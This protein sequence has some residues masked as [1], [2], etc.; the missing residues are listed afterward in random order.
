MPRPILNPSRSF[1][2]VGRGVRSA[3]L[4]VAILGFTLAAKTQANAAETV[5][6]PPADPKAPPTSLENWQKTAI[7][8]FQEANKNFAK[9]AAK[10]TGEEARENRLGEA[11]TLLAL[12]PRTQ[13]N[14][15]KAQTIFEELISQNPKDGIG[16]AARL[17]LGRLFQV[18][19]TPTDPEKARAI[20]SELVADGAGDPLA[21]LAAYRL[22]NIELYSADSPEA[23]N[24]AARKLAP[25]GET[26]KTPVGRRE[27]YGSLAAALYRFHGDKRLAMEYFI[28]AKDQGISVQ[29]FDSGLLIVI[30][31]LAEELGETEIAK[32]YY[33]L[34]VNDYKRDARRHAVIQKLKQLGVS[35]GPDSDSPLSP[36]ANPAAATTPQSGG[37]P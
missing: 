11:V 22:V 1:P 35:V 5:A 29:Q 28:I 37:N 24:A 12:Q 18:H 27:F 33:T 6:T 30:G 10:Q 2:L 23:M 32:K 15:T 7:F 13:G 9:A 19:A 8:L 3:I 20:Y 31:S 36:E 21:E 17:H 25:L 4:G 16:F 14:I 34:F 26:L